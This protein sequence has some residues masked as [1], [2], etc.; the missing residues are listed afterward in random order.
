MIIGVEPF[1]KF[2]NLMSKKAVIIGS[3]IAG[4][5][6]AI[7]LRLKGYQVEVF[8]K[9]TYPG[10]KL[11]E[12][13]GAGFRFDAGPSL[14]TMPQYV[15]E[16]FH[17][18]GRDPREYYHYSKL[19]E[20]CR[21]FWNDQTRFVTRSD[22]QIMAK[23]AAEVFDTQSNQFL[24]KIER[25]AY[26]EETTGKLFLEQTL[27]DWKGFINKEALRAIIR[28]PKL[29]LNKTLHEVNK[30]SFKDPKLVQLFDRY[31]TYNGSSPYQTPGIMEVIPH[32]EY[33]VGAF[34]P[35]K[36]MVE[37]IHSVVRLAK[38]IGVVFSF[39]HEVTE[40]VCDKSVVKGIRLANGEQIHAQIVVSNMDVYYTYSRLLK[41]VSA[42]KRRLNQERSSSALI[43]YWGVN[44]QFEELGVHNV[45]F[46]D[47]YKAEFE[48]VFKTEVAYKDPTI[49]LHISSKIKEDDAP[50]DAENWF[51]MI[52]TP[53]KGQVNWNEYVEQ[54][55]KYVQ[56]KLSR[57]LNVELQN[58]IV[59]EEMLSPP[60]LELRTY[61]YQ[62]SLYGA[63][64][65]SRYAAFLRQPNFHR[66]LKGLYFVG[67]S[68]HPGGGIPLCLL[69][70]K[71]AANH[72]PSV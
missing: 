37:I 20:I 6:A 53:P 23:E 55:K 58:L 67:G 3:G 27:H 61:A 13:K 30:R 1:V 52:N 54:A 32:Y 22:Q 8:E 16:L 63:S 43:F 38:E 72:V 36:G 42:P 28:M 4:L 59:F 45:L 56:K 31:A 18:S 57:L 70:A 9:N 29:G 2:L 68:V 21:Y 50:Q 47:D 48:A 40:I 44:K 71:I 19:G 10:G 14:F 26:I 25:A 12:I 34:F 5:A 46:A 17:L 51:V 66:K 65:N 49:Y 41:G 60:N 39:G 62:G 33:N 11:S 7:R 15:D 35:E 24:E 64:S 69:S